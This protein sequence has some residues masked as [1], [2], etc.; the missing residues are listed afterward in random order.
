MRQARS[1]MTRLVAGVTVAVLAGLTAAA[2]QEPS[3]P[4]QRGERLFMVQGC[5]GCHTIGKVGT[6]IGPDLSLVGF[7][8]PEPYL[9]RW[10]RDPQDVRP[11]AHM[12]RLELEAAD[13]EALAA[14]LAS[15]R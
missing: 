6:P 9:R 12:P 2:A 1:S 13:V 5:Y 14:F 4:R 3:D 7:K 15:L 10:L 8:Y 11:T